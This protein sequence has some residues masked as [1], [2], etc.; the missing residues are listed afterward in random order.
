MRLAKLLSPWSLWAGFVLAILAAAAIGLNSVRE[1]REAAAWSNWII[2]TQRVLA[3][4][5]HARTTSFEVFYAASYEQPGN[6]SRQAN[7]RAGS[8]G[9]LRRQAVELHYLTSDNREQQIRLAVIDRLQQRLEPLSGTSGGKATASAGR[10]PGGMQL[11]AGLRDI[12]YAMRQQLDEMSATERGLLNERRAKLVSSMQQNQRVLEIGGGVIFVWLFAL[13]GVAIRRGKR[14]ERTTE[15]L[16]RGREELSRVAERERGERRFRRLLE[17]APDALF[18]LDSKR[19]I[20]M[21]NAQAEKLYGYSRAELMAAAHGRS[22]LNACI[23]FVSKPLD[24][25]SS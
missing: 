18:I 20:L 23:R 13:A 17:S 21:A 10:H 16:S 14:L 3:A 11:I 7:Q 12:L 5:D 4:L 2:H 24:Q 15:A 25:A 1:G 8:I 22:F 19:R 9:S 6:T